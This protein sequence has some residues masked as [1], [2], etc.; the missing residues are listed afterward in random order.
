M[1]SHRNVVGNEKNEEAKKRI[2]EGKG[3]SYRFSN[4]AQFNL[5][6]TEIEGYKDKADSFTLFFV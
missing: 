3:D 4:P 2:G 6:P 1:W 5:S